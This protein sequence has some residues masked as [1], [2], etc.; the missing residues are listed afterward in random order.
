MEGPGTYDNDAVIY[1]SSDQMPKRNRTAEKLEKEKEKKEEDKKNK[2][3]GPYPELEELHVP[4]SLRQEL[5]NEAWKKE[6]KK[7]EEAKKK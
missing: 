1:D 5:V 3:L 4:D 6:N 7:R 2:A